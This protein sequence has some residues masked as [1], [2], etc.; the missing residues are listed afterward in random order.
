MQQ[1]FSIFGVRLVGLSTTVGK[2][3]LFT[4]ILLALLWFLHFVISKLVQYIINRYCANT[5]TSFWARQSLNVITAILLLLGLLS[6]WFDNPIRLATA[7]GLVTAGMAF[8]LQKVIISLAGYL[9]ILRGN[10][11]NV[12]DRISMGGVR[13]DV[14]ALGF[15]QTTLMEM[16]EPPSVQDANP[17][18]WVKSRQ[19]TGRVVTITND[20]VFD[21]PVYNYTRDFPYLW[22]EISIPITY[23]TNR[24]KAEHILQECAHRHTVHMNAMSQEALEKMQKRYNVQDADLETKVYYRITDN[25]LELTVRFVVREHAI[26]EIKDAISRDI[27]EA[28]DQAGIGIASSTFDIVG[29]PPIHL[30]RDVRRESHTQ[31]M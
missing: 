29:L 13:G 25:W 30:E 20:K 2:K 21:E 31:K 14:I 4:L 24:K 3:V 26:R 9:V 8:A 7:L 18:I 19:Y 28:F 5:Y 10:T 1:G 6:I 17:P 16:G 23:H 12:G 15:I 22:E 27:L 11:F